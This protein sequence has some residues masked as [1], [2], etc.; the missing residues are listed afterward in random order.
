MSKI[1]LFIHI[2]LAVI[3][4]VGL[5]LG[6]LGLS[7]MFSVDLPG[8]MKLSERSRQLFVFWSFVVLLISWIFFYIERFSTIRELKIR[9]LRKRNLQSALDGLSSLRSEG[10]T[11]LFAKTPTA[12]KFN[13]WIENFE[14]WEN[15]VIRY[16]NENFTRSIAGLI[17]ELGAL[18]L[19]KFTQTIKDP[20][21][22]PIH[23]H[24]LQMIN[25]ILYVMEKVISQESAIV[26]EPNPSFWESLV[27]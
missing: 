7:I 14:D 8:L 1:R 3:S 21:L 12:T 15:R 20:K 18:P 25:K 10:I 6:T 11:E 16:M 19:V 24:K 17:S 9:L 23:E 2:V 26:Q 5:V 4:L 27:N 13:A 22:A